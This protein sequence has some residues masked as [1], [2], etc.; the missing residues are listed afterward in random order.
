MK[1]NNKINIIFAMLIIVFGLFLCSII[2]IH[3]LKQENILLKKTYSEIYNEE[4][5]E[6]V[7][8]YLCDGTVKIQPVND[9]FY[10]ECEKCELRTDFYKSK[11][12]LITYWNKE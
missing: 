3:Q 2:K 4:K 8:C 11:I 5:I 10:I 12:D 6:L 9:S 1:K 7:P